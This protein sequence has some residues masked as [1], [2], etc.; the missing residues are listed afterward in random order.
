[1][2]KGSLHNTSQFIPP[3]RRVGHHAQASRTHIVWTSPHNSSQ[4]G[5][6]S[7]G[8][9]YSGVDV[10]YIACSGW[11]GESLL[12]EVCRTVSVTPLPGHEKWAEY[13][14]RITGLKETL[15]LTMIDKAMAGH[16]MLEGGE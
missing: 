1:M 2:V 5:A 6:G 4:E 7:R 11:R 3:C 9:Y 14:V 16:L 15:V 13:F 10:E 12:D 8:A